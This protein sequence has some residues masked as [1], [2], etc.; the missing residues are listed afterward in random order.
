MFYNSYLVLHNMGVGP[1]LGNPP[2]L[3]QISF[4]FSHQMLRVSFVDSGGLL[5]DL[6]WFC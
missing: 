4:V 5:S 2:S 3:L 1:K 6:N